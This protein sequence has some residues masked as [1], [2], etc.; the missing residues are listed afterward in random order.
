MSHC[1]SRAIGLIAATGL[2]ENFSSFFLVE[3]AHL[4]AETIEHHMWGQGEGM[5][6]LIVALQSK[7]LGVDEVPVVY[8]PRLS[9]ESKTDLV[10]FLADYVLAALRIRRDRPRPVMALIG[11]LAQVLPVVLLVWV[12]LENPEV[13]ASLPG[14]LIPIAASFAFLVCSVLMRGVRFRGIVHC[15]GTKPGLR[16]LTTDIIG[17]RYWNEALPMRLGDLL[18]L[19]RLS[20]RDQVPMPLAIAMLVWEK[21]VGFSTGLVALATAFIVVQFGSDF[22]GPQGAEL[23]VLVGVPIVLSWVLWLVLIG[24][25]S[26]VLRWILKWFDLERFRAEA[27]EVRAQLVGPDW[28]LQ[29]PFRPIEGQASATLEDLGSWR[30]ALGPGPLLAAVLSSFAVWAFVAASLV[31]LAHAFGVD[32]P[33]AVLVLCAFGTGAAVQVRFLPGGFGQVELTQAVLLNACGVPIERAILLAAAYVISVRLT[34]VV[35]GLGRMAMSGKSS[36]GQ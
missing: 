25:F 7:G 28:T 8:G 13:F 2:R 32:A 31:C 36:D 12:C 3:R 4:D 24:T 16:R 20:Q 18:R 14:A 27:R 11:R 29:L 22:I 15:S 9:G 30:S 26:G 10:S 33:I 19:E 35:L 5:L 21:V 1:A 34:N 17:G 6:R 23:G